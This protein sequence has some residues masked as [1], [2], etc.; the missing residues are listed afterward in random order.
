MIEL[1]KV[2]IWNANG[3]CQ[4]IQELQIFLQEMK[5]DII[6]ISETHFTGKSYCK[7]RNY[8]IYSTNHPDNKGHGGTAVIFKNNIKHHELNKYSKEHIQATTVAIEDKFGYM[9]ISAVYCPPKYNNKREQ[10]EMF[11]NTLGNRFIAGGD[12]N[13]KHIQ[14]GSRLTTTKGRELF[15]TIIKNNLNF[16]STGQP[17]YWPTDPKKIPDLIDFCITKGINTKNC[18]TEMSLNLTSDHTP[19]LVTLNTSFTTVKKKWYSV[20]KKQ[21]GQYLERHS[22]NQ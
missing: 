9:N 17:T 8:T 14:W 6:L 22:K 18:V 1:L 16:I 20:E 13:A 21:I 2:G 7:L 12:F 5:I 10:Y 19:V 3:L 11:F 4:H 15:S